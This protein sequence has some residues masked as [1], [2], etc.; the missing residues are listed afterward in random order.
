MT[1]TSI[2]PILKVLQ[3]G[4]LLNTVYKKFKLF[5]VLPK[6]GGF[7]GRHWVIPVQY[8]NGGSRSALV[9]Y[10]KAQVA[11]PDME[12]FQIKR[13]SDY[14]YGTITGE[15]LEAAA[16][17][18]GAFTRSLQNNLDSKNRELMRAAEISL[19]RDGTGWI[20][21]ISASATV[22]STSLLLKNKEE[23]LCYEKGDE[24][25]GSSDGANDH[26]G[27]LW[28][29]GASGTVTGVNAATGVLT[30]ATNWNAATEIQGVTASDF[31][32]AA[33]DRQTA[34]VT[35]YTVQRKVWGLM[36]WAPP[37]GIM[38]PMDASAD[39]DEASF[40]FCAV[41]R[42]SHSR[43]AGSFLD[44]SA[45]SLVEEVVIDAAN[46]AH[47]MGESPR[48][49]I[50]NPKF[51]KRL[52]KELS[53]KVQY[54]KLVAQGPKGAMAKIGFEGIKLDGPDGPVVVMQNVFCPADYGFC[55]NPSSFRLK[56]LGGVPKFLKH[57]D[58]KILRMA[59]GASDAD[60]TYEFVCAYRMNMACEF[61]GGQVTVT[62]P[63]T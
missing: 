39:I 52:Q 20:S 18:T 45:Y 7:S 56:S 35:A 13:I 40:P 63:T 33:G 51:Y 26:N 59:I 49:F 27:V 62:M 32:Y 55:I 10:A 21:D 30:A 28:N 31:L 5:A 53:T 16:D 14:S 23:A 25:V 61:P 1:V 38:H 42:K 8:G 2:D 58:N 15:A 60:V 24:L 48:L 46:Q 36:S 3:Q 34:Q 44:A 4:S 57:D 41:S 37:T 50:M 6:E 12:D 9:G 17:D 47:S 43:L 54:D 29:S 22:A 19:F 11:S